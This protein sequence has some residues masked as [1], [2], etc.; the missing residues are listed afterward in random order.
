VLIFWGE[1]AVSRG[2]IQGNRRVKEKK[3]ERRGKTPTRLAQGVRKDKIEH[4]RRKT[5][6]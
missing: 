6:S 5:E 2:E 3:N 1:G 4:G